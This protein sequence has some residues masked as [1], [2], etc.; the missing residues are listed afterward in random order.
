MLIWIPMDSKN[1]EDAIIVTLSEVKAWALVEFHEG[2][3]GEI[4][5]FDERDNQNVF[6]EFIV[7]K[8][9]FENSMEFMQEGMMVL[10]AR[11]QEN[12]EEIM[13]SFKF[14]ELDELGI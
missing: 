11:Y 7:L 3:V 9:R 10:I 6:A 2:V 12:I 13:E 1:E 4:K 8:N 5:F 14:K